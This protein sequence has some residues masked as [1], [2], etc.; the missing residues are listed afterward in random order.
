MP[1]PVPLHNQDATESDCPAL[2]RNVNVTLPDGDEES[3][4]LAEVDEESPDMQIDPA[5]PSRHA[6]ELGAISR[7]KAAFKTL[8]WGASIEVL[9]FS[10]RF[11][12][13]MT[14][15]SLFLVAFPASEPWPDSIWILITCVFV[16]W[17]PSIDAGSVFK[18]LLERIAGTMVGA[19][20]AFAV[21]HVSL[22]IGSTQGQAV[23]L[24]FV[25]A[26][27]G[28]LYPYL[29]DRLG[30]RNS[31]GALVGTMTFGIA[32]FA[33]YEVIGDKPPW[34]TALYR[35]LNIIIGCIISAAVSVGV[36]PVSTRRLLIRNVQSLIAATGKDAG[37][38]LHAASQ[39]FE[40]GTKPRSLSVLLRELDSGNAAPDPVHSSYV[41]DVE[42]LKN[43]RALIPVIKYDPWFW[44]MRKEERRELIHAM[45]MLV[46]RT[47]AVQMNIILLDSILRSDAEYKGP[48]EAIG[49]LPLI[50]KRIETALSVKLL[51]DQE[52]N[53]A[54]KELLDEYLPLIRMHTRRASCQPSLSGDSTLPN[55]EHIES[56]LEAGPSTL[57]FSILNQHGGQTQ[58]FFQLLEQ[59][60]LRVAKL[61]FSLQHYQ[62]FIAHRACDGCSL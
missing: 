1:S 51:D 9:V 20:L 54:V 41:K 28:F 58:L 26:V 19:V 23:F 46:D 6:S 14:M 25:F 39:S 55:Y 48:A 4:Q 50:G 7:F 62:P 36:Y 12:V 16:T 10:C 37:M 21:G 11:S 32:L 35:V 17:Q 53:A 5:P 22:G 40:S 30:Y 18:K 15:A 3:K 45:I 34:V 27:E 44:R 29:A 49:L 13:S 42:G 2:E 24:G 52:R 33:F 47:I 31:Y 59:L 38:V 8:V 43:T 56:I 57:P 61:H 60:I